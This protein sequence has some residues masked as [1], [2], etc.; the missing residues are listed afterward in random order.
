MYKSI[1]KLREIGTVIPTDLFELLVLLCSIIMHMGVFRGDSSAQQCKNIR[2]RYN[3]KI[4]SKI[5]ADD[6]ERES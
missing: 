5:K 1:K 4:K 2:G 6:R 3:K